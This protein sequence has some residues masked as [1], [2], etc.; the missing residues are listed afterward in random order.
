MPAPA[1]TFDEKRETLAVGS[2]IDFIYFEAL[3]ADVDSWDFAGLPPGLSGN[4]ATGYITGAATVGGIFTTTV[5]GTNGDGSDSFVIQWTVSAS[6]GVPVANAG[7]D[8]HVTPTGD[9][10][11]TPT[12]TGGT[13]T[14]WAWTSLPAGCSF[15]P[16]T[17]V[18]SGRITTPGTY[19]LTVTASNSS[20]TGPADGL[21]IV[22][23]ADYSGYTG[24]HASLIDVYIEL[25][26]GV[27]STV[28]GGVT[29]VPLFSHKYGDDKVLNVVFTRR[30]V[31][32]AM[33]LESLKLVLKAFEPEPA[34]LTA[35]GVE[36]DLAWHDDGDAFR[37]Y[38]PLYSESLRSAVAEN[39]TD[40]VTEIAA[41]AEFEWIEG[42]GYTPAVGPGTLRGSSGTFRYLLTR[43][44]VPND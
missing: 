22:V 16:A 12:F 34:V 8:V 23:A 13:P 26:T 29:A 17:G 30:G 4:T 25:T 41:L 10:S 31:V 32:T 14:T 40:A 44:L 42:N 36:G 37:L 33:A 28:K 6:T 43:D 1:F 3:A 7:P 5:T 38:V 19:N 27:V 9:V 35:G 20:G 15:N 24:S 18:L 21:A 2:A 11:V 39:E